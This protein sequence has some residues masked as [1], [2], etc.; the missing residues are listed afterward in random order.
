MLSMLVANAYENFQKQTGYPPVRFWT[1]N[2][3]VVKARV[4]LKWAI[5]WPILVWFSNWSLIVEII[6]LHL[7][8][9]VLIILSVRNIVMQ[10]TNENKRE[11]FRNYKFIIM[12]S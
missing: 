12:G 10:S 9:R 4:F 2:F 6:P 5:F 3:L 1:N 8:F 7:G 11:V